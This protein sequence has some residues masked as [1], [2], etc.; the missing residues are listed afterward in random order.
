MI[1][2]VIY[3]SIFFVCVFA[4]SISLFACGDSAKTTNDSTTIEKNE[5]D[6]IQNLKFEISGSKD[7]TCT[8]VGYKTFYGDERDNNIVIPS[9]Y[10]GIPVTSIGEYA[11]YDWSSLTSITI[12]GGVTSIGD[13]AFHNCRSLTSI[14]IPSSVTSIG[15]SAFESCNKLQ[16]NEYDNACYLGNKVIQYVVLVKVKNRDINQCTINENCRIIGEY[17]FYNC[18][19]LTSIEIP[20]SVTS[21]GESAF[22][23]CDS[24][25][26]IAVTENNEN[27]K[28]IDGNLYSKDGTVLLQYVKGKQDISFTIP[29]CVT[30]IGNYAFYNCDSLT[31]IEIPSSVTIIG[32]EAFYNCNELQYNEYDNA[33]YLGNKVNQYVALVE[34]KNRD[35]NQCTINENC[36]IIG[37]YSF[38]N[39]DSLTSIEIPSSVT[40]IG[41]SAFYDCDS[42][43][44][45]EIPSSVTSI[46][47]SAFEDCDSLASIAVAENN[48]NYKS[49]D[50]NLYSKDGTVL[51]QYAKGKQDISF[52][53]PSCV[54]SIGNYA[55]YNCYSLT[56]IEIPSS[57]TSIGEFAFHN[58]D[59]LTSITIPE[60]VTNIRYYAFYGCSSLTSITIPEGVT[61]IGDYAFYDCDSL[62]SIEIPSSVTSIGEYAFYNCDSL[63]KVYYKGNSSQ[64]SSVSIRSKNYPLKS[65]TIYYYSET[66][67]AGVG[68]YWYYDENGEIAIWP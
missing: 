49:I 28:S 38:Y 40:S 66:E 36:R 20:S 57:V 39:C 1:K 15:K 30:S 4:L 16:Y 58:C 32:G 9:K 47:E 5:T 26:S 6:S 2:K 37:E 51:L 53:I 54:T 3:C 10:K 41:E 22:Y 25:A 60:G 44:S 31:S 48:S 29:S 7:K 59:S 33:C 42:L 62:A 11:F 12:P 34:V 23:D 43:A 52:A 46:G 68:N 21:I 17:S 65:E 35:I 13:H 64:W 67:P 61:N 18:D 55:F 27:Y 50:G 45:I 63:T 56:S 24:L 19:S 14:E 8:V